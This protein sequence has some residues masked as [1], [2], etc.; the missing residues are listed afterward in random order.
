MYAT[1]TVGAHCVNYV[2]A[3][4]SDLD[5][6]I[7]SDMDFDPLVPRGDREK[8]PH[9]PPEEEG[10]EPQQEV[11]HVV[12]FFA[13]HH[14]NIPTVHGLNVIPMPHISVDVDVHELLA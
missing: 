4:S 14:D 12:D 1:V 5:I 10:H 2:L 6:K 13:T 11:Q 3:Q 7:V 9:N 8:K